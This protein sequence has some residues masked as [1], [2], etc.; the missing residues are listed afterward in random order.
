MGEPV[1]KLQQRSGEEEQC[2][3]EL[4]TRS[5]LDL[6]GF[7][8]VWDGLERRLVILKMLAVVS[9]G[10]SGLGRAVTKVLAEHGQVLAGV[11]VLGRRLDRLEATAREVEAIASE[12]GSTAKV[13]P[14]ICDVSDSSHI[15]KAVAEIKANFDK[16]YQIGVLV[17]AAGTLQEGLLMRTSEKV[18]EDT[19]RVNLLGP[20]LLSKAVLKD[21]MRCASQN[22]T[23][24]SSEKAWP[25]PSIVNIGSVVGSMGN[26]GQTVYSASKAGLAGFSK[27]L[28]RELAGKKIRV[29]LVEPGFLATDMTEHLDA[30]STSERIPLGRFGYTD[31]V[32]SMVEYL[33]LNPQSSYVT[34]QVFRVD[35]G[36]AM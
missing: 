9:G 11:A 2:C 7:G 23:S 8:Q 16:Q 26:A 30:E 35:G 31:E 5:K 18:M 14:V 6:G 12:K 34:G 17:N 19:L 24:W 3:R 21:L 20:M 33:T 36:L 25:G 32:A 1:S 22:P 27:S 15:A 28:A 13:L 29:N 10:G 4:E